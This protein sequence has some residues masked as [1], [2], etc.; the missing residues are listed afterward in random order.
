MRSGMQRAARRP[1]NSE[2]SVNLVLLDLL[3]LLSS[4]RL[5]EATTDTFSSLK[6]TDWPKLDRFK[7]LILE[8][9]S[10]WR[11]SAE[12]QLE[13]QSEPIIWILAK[14]GFHSSEL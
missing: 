1:T 8:I 5:L 10:A 2:N 4:S 7:F 12:L 11:E 13:S 3:D 6:K 9:L 14:L